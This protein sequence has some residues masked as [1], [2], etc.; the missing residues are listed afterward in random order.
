MVSVSAGQPDF[1]MGADGTAVYFFNPPP[2]QQLPSSGPPSVEE[3]ETDEDAE[4]L[5]AVG[6]EAALK[7]VDSSHVQGDQHADKL[8]VSGLS[9][10][11]AE[12]DESAER[13]RS[14]GVEAARKLLCSSHGGGKRAGHLDPQ[15]NPQLYQ[16]GEMSASVQPIPEP[17]QQQQ[18]QH[19]HSSEVGSVSEAYSEALSDMVYEPADLHAPHPEIAPVPVD[20]EPQVSAADGVN[21]V[22]LSSTGVSGEISQPSTM[23]LVRRHVAF[24]R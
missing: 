20:E 8:S 21:P 1:E 11:D 2:S 18:Q 3:A 12:T 6:V 5:R 16:S 7:L 15:P 17:Q 10:A 4:R 24:I 9:I 22:D 19:P 13:R 23:S 14:R